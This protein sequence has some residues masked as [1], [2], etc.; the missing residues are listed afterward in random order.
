MDQR[1][2][3]GRRYTI[4]ADSMAAIERIQSDAIGPGQRFTVAANE[5]GTRLM[6]RNNE[7]AIHWVPTH[8]GVQ[9]NETADEM[10][11]AA[12]E[13]NHPDDALAA[14]DE[15][16][17]E[18]SF[19][20]MARVA[21]ENR[22]RTTTEWISSRTGASVK[23]QGPSGKRSQAQAPSEGAKVDRGKVLS[24]AVRPRGDRPIPRRQYPQ[25]G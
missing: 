6:S 18:T 2:E 7:A 3:A 19:S 15:L 12:A 13:G 21:T 5:V 8:H 16:R 17:W 20:Q 23:V 1:Q 22:S 9:G 11:R 10:A 4:F 25:D 24:A 14:P